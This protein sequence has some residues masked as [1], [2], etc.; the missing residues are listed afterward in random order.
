MNNTQNIQLNIGD[1][2]GFVNLAQGIDENDRTVFFPVVQ[3]TSRGGE[4]AYRYMY[5]DGEISRSSIPQSQLGNYSLKINKP[6]FGV[7]TAP[8]AEMIS[9]SERKSEFLEAMKRGAENRLEI[10]NGWD[11]DSFHVKNHDSGKEYQV[12][13]KTSDGETFGQCD[14]ADAIFR[15]RVCKHLA[16]VVSQSVFGLMVRS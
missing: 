8:K 1:E 16:E 15:K 12:I 6:K 9:L 5:P 7:P 11:R 2:I 10:F 3:I 13:L 14:C 4:R